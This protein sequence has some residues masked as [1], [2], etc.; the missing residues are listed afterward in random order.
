MRA[1]V[2]ACMRACVCVPVADEALAVEEGEVEAEL[3]GRDDA[4]RHR[5]RHLIIRYQA[6]SGLVLSLI[7]ILTYQK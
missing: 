7:I 2:R 6:C 3:Q 5:H 4:R 1:C